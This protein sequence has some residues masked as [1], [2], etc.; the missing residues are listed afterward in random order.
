MTPT[1]TCAVRVIVAVWS[2]ANV[3][4]ATTAPRCV[5]GAFIALETIAG[6]PSAP[7]PFVHVETPS[8]IVVDIGSEQALVSARPASASASRARNHGQTAPMPSARRCSIASRM[9][10]IPAATSPCCPS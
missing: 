6:L 2:S 10:A 1:P 8:L 3:G 9:S 4:D 5:P 7:G